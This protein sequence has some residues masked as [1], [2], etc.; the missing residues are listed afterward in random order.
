MPLPG[1]AAD[2]YGNRYEG[3]WTVQCMIQILHG[4]YSYIFLEEPGEDTAEFRLM[5]SDGISEQHQVKRQNG[6]QAYWRIKDL[7][8]KGILQA[9]WDC[10]ENPS[11]RYVFVSTDNV[12]GLT[13][14]LDRATKTSSSDIF[15]DQYLSTSQKLRK[16]FAGIATHFHTS[17]EET[18]SRIKRLNVETISEAQLRQKVEYGVKAF[19]NT[20]PANAV[21][22]LAQYALNNVHMQLGRD[23]IV[24]H[25]KQREIF[26]DNP[27]KIQMNKRHPLPKKPNPFI[28]RASIIRTLVQKFNSDVRVVIIKAVDGAGKT[29][30]L[31]EFI[32]ANLD[33]CFYFFISRDWTSNT[34]NFMRDV[35]RQ[36]QNELGENNDLDS[37]QYDDLKDIFGRLCRAISRFG[38]QRQRPYYL[39][40]DGLE[41]AQEE[42][43]RASILDLIQ[44]EFDG[45]CILGSTNQDLQIRVPHSVENL[46]YFTPADTEKYLSG[47]DLPQDQVRGIYQIS[48]GLP[49]YL[50]QLKREIE[51]GNQE[52]EVLGDLPSGFHDLL[53]RHWNLQSYSEDEF[54]LLAMLAH[55]EVSFDDDLLAAVLKTTKD[56]IQRSIQNIN[57][58]EKHSNRIK[59]VTEAHRSFVAEKLQHREENVNELLITYYKK[60]LF[61]EES[62]ERLPLLLHLRRSKY[63]ILKEIVNVDY[64][65]KSFSIT[66]DMSLLRRNTQLMID[67]ANRFGEQQDLATLSK[68]SLMSSLLRTFTEESA[69][70]LEVQAL[71]A[72]GE[73]QKSVALAYQAPLLED[74]LELLSAIGKQL[75]QSNGSILNNVILEIE[76]MIADLVPNVILR[77]RAVDIATDLFVVHPQAALDLLEKVSDTH[78]KYSIDILLAVLAIRL[79]GERQTVTSGLTSRIADEKLREFIT[80]NSSTI[81]GLSAQEAISEAEKITDISGQLFLL[82]SWCNENRDDLEAIHIVEK[83]LKIIQE[84]PAGDYAPSMLHLRQLAEPL[85]NYE[86]DQIAQVLELFRDIKETALSQPFEEAVRLDLILSRLEGKN[87]KPVMYK[88]IFD[89]YQ[90]LKNIEDLDVRCYCY[91]QILLSISKVDF[92][93]KMTDLATE[94]ESFLPEI[95]DELLAGSRD[96]F[97]VTERILRA[98]TKYNY[99][100]AFEFAQRLNISS[101]RDDAYAEIMRVYVGSID[102]LDSDTFLSQVLDLV[103]NVDHRNQILILLLRDFSRKFDLKS[104]SSVESFIHRLTSINDPVDLAF[105][106]GHAFVLYH[107]A[108]LQEESETCFQEMINVWKQIDPLP[109]KVDV[110]FN[111]VILLSEHT[112]EKSRE[113]YQLVSDNRKSHPLANISLM[114]M[115]VNLIG[116]SI[117]AIAVH[118]NKSDFDNRLDELIFNIQ[119]IPSP[120]FQMR[121]FCDLAL[122]F[123]LNELQPY[124]DKLINDYIF[125]IIDENEET[126]YRMRLWD[127]AAPILFYSSRDLFDQAVEELDQEHDDVIYSVIVSLVSKHSPADPISLENNNFTVDNRIA[128]EVCGLIERLNTDG[129]IHASISLLVRS[130]IYDDVR[131]HVKYNQ[132]CYLSENTALII[133]RRLR[134]LIDTKL[135]ESRNIRHKGFAIACLALLGRL[136]DVSKRA[137]KRWSEFVPAWDVLIEQAGEIPNIPD[138]ILVLTWISELV[139]PS[140]EDLAHKLVVQAQDLVYDISNVID[141]SDSLVEVAQAWHKLDDEKSTQYLL[142]E[143]MKIIQGLSWDETKDQAA[144]Q[145]LQAAHAINPA[146]ASSLTSTVDNPIIQHRLQKRVYSKDL[147]RDP[148]KLKLDST[149][150]DYRPVV[151]AAYEITKAIA[152]GKFRTILDKSMLQWLTIGSELPFFLSY[153]IRL[154]EIQNYIGA[155][156][157]TRQSE[158][159][160]VHANLLDGLKLV[161]LIG[162]EMFPHFNSNNVPKSL[163]IEPISSEEDLQNLLLDWLDEAVNI[164]KLAIYDTNFGYHDLKLI[165]KWAPNARIRIFTTWTAQGLSVGDASVEDLFRKTWDDTSE[166]SPYDLQIT[167]LETSSD[168][169][170]IQDRCYLLNDDYGIE[171][172]PNRSYLEKSYAHVRELRTEE[173]KERAQVYLDQ[174]EIQ[175]IRSYN[176]ER[177]IRRIIHID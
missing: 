148:D 87:S 44:L 15:L 19:V 10:T 105:G 107:K 56:R 6:S 154:M 64:L 139:M 20:N 54:E 165:L 152:S 51:D 95:F 27:A 85:I 18:F 168:Y 125:P 169:C 49:A 133:A 39:V 151:S 126:M 65:S 24:N 55:A 115:Y 143:A 42:P 106:Y 127:I 59:F 103:S 70:K 31:T 82:R 177:I 166:E 86:Y 84:A 144:A 174:F 7:Q 172:I 99:N 117:K 142:T 150:E 91:V 97:K 53:D 164:N 33:D 25:L 176:D 61:T 135:P 175:P 46:G 104:S 161:G 69:D 30:V 119:Q 22:I 100:L 63:E 153:P 35:C 113:F 110:G 102:R 38:Q 11:Q 17:Y 16:I 101:R 120:I 167:L 62:L 121:H 2:K 73:Y 160:E 23:D 60:D 159:T 37:L 77:E 83:A 122:R 32:E 93:N 79:E 50:D 9:F 3:L 162:A 80:A 21:D 136:R 146:L 96:Q 71:L 137:K 5:R 145:I 68:F 94:I 14:I 138:R 57:F 76:R 36:F 34:V 155:S 118:K 47:L 129:I 1:G 66:K 98:L 40:V 156:R 163:K 75:K 108:N 140:D 88:Q 112:P 28:S 45:L 74:K 132:S 90:S 52:I 29:T 81:A 124:T 131:P 89:L 26:V 147:I 48:E 109:T 58:V 173:A 170:P 12:E 157:N 134:S 128:L 116:L 67:A 149:L 78:G 111:L 4:E 114:E 130:S 123:H 171:I 92:D 141:R 43:G 72:I 8:N 13:E 158:L 41:N